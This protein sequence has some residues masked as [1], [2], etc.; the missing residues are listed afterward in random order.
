[1]QEPHH[2]DHH[3]PSRL[4]RALA[5][6]VLAFA[7]APAAAAATP[8][9]LLLPSPLAPLSLSPPLSGGATASA[10]GIRH[11]ISA[12]TAVRVSVDASGQPFAVTATQRLDVGVTGDY[13]FT[14]GAPTL[15]VEAARGSE[16]TPGRRSAS[17]IWQGFDPGRRTLAARVV[18]DPRL[19]ARALPLRIE[20]TADHVT[21]VNTT[22]ITVG[23]FDADVERA[24]LLRYFAQLRRDVES[25]HPPS[26]GE[27]SITTPSR[28]TTFRTWATLRIFGT[29]GGLPFARLLGEAPATIAAG[30]PIRLTVD[31]V[32]PTALLRP[33][34]GL[35]GRALLRRVT[36]ALLGVAR[37]RQYSAY[38]GNPDPTGPNES[39][40]VYASA[41]PPAPVAAVAPALRTGRDWTRTLLVAAALLAAAALG[42]VAWA[43]S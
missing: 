1:V 5:L 8:R 23:G 3:H 6:V 16:A 37:A 33:A 22:G 32:P 19:A 20:V 24:P 21:L 31:P 34:P 27:T 9:V 42:V 18:L 43:R 41:K 40:Y 12:T 30:G 17:I 10:E 38:L 4:T 25:G 35:S 29:I 13:F 28:A 36:L 7:A 15:D 2:G 26:P 39:T 11:R 14:I